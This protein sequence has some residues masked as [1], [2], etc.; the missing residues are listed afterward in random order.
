MQLP[1]QITFRNMPSSEAVEAKV[2][3]RAIKLKRYFENILSCK[4][5]IEAPHK[6]HHKGSIFQVNIDVSVP[7]KEIVV[8]RERGLNH[9]H[10]DIYVAVRDAFAAVRRQL[11]EYTK[12]RLG[13]AKRLTGTVPQQWSEDDLPEMAMPV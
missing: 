13:K 10:E 6:H 11:E 9:A 4:V 7:G 5:T 2:K 8:S 1:L 3:Q 12:S